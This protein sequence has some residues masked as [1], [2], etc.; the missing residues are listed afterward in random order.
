[1]KQMIHIFKKDVR[2]FWWEICILLALLALYAWC[3]PAEWFGSINAINQTSTMYI[4]YSG[5]QMGFVLVLLWAVL[6]IGVVFEEAPAGDRQF[7]TTRPYRWQS[8][9]AAKILFCVATVHVP[10][11]IVQLILLKAAGFAAFHSLGRLIWMNLGLAA[12]LSPVAA[13]ATII[14]N[15]SQFLR[16]ALG[17]ILI[18][19]ICLIAF[20]ATGG[21][22][23]NLGA[24][25]VMFA[26][27][28][29]PWGRLLTLLAIGLLV[30][31]IVRQYAVQKTTQA[32]WVAL[33]GVA[34]LVAMNFVIPETHLNAAVYPAL[35]QES[36]SYMQLHMSAPS[37]EHSFVPIFARDDKHILINL[38]LYG[39]S[40]PEGYIVQGNGIKITLQ[41]ADGTRWSSDWQEIYTLL[42]EHET[43]P[44]GTEIKGG[45]RTLS[46][47]FAVDKSFYERFKGSPVTVHVDVAATLLQDHTS[48]LS[49]HNGDAVIPNIG[50]CHI[51]NTTTLGFYC[52]SDLERVP[53]FGI[54]SQIAKDCLTD[55]SGSTNIW[56]N[57]EWERA[58]ILAPLQTFVPSINQYPSKRTLT[59][60]NNRPLILRRPEKIRQFQTGKDF[61]GI[62]L[63]GYSYRLG[64]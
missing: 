8:L 6:L 39:D 42:L 13:L 48:Q 56:W 27:N 49:E 43:T 32:R 38:N 50:F 14:K 11:L 51:N 55:E 16:I 60:C 45:W 29:S 5:A 3:Q 20:A 4:R 22:G 35:N 23:M 59:E 63:G 53:L 10:L 31:V 37:T 52:R 18:F 40:V 25:Y 33:A 19:I 64:M 57:F 15:R 44:P 62:K 28:E 58:S 1:M 47:N 36:P 41:A 46:S 9:L 30:L 34:L 26:G 24:S 54:T 2:R 17:L 61:T 7:W 12:L 21:W